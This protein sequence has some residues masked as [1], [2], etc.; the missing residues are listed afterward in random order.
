M[1]KLSPVAFIVRFFNLIIPLRIS[2]LNLFFS[3]DVTKNFQI[4][5]QITSFTIPEMWRNLTALSSRTSPNHFT[6]SFQV[7]SQ[8]TPIN[9]T[10]PHAQFLPST[11]P[12]LCDFRSFT[13]GL[14]LFFWGPLPYFFGRSLYFKVPFLSFPL[15]PMSPIAFLSFSVDLWSM[16]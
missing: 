15:S 11:F 3:Y 9:P 12:L 2:F 5:F 6:S 4:I 14:Y 1:V 7:G 13:L 8:N 16:S 10:P